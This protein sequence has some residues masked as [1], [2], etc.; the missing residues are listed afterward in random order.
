MNEQIPTLTLENCSLVPL[1]VEDASA[2]HRVYQGEDMLKY[3]PD[4]NPPPLERVERFIVSQ[5]KHWEQRGY[6]NWGL[7]PAGEN[8]IIGWAGL[9]YLPELAETEVGFLL[10]RSFWG[11]GIATQAA[12]AA[13]RFGF[14]TC[15]LPRIIALVHPDNL[16]SRRVIGKCGMAYEETIHLWGIDLMRHCLDRT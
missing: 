4:R 16:A 7:L 12:R 3:F 13:L 5:Q 1:R 10:D 9:Q 8:Q 2:L 11:R 15:N 6:G 14:E